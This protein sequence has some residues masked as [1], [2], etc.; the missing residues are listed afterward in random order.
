MH[1]ARQLDPIRIIDRDTGTVEVEVRIPERGM[2][3]ALRKLIRIAAQHDVAVPLAHRRGVRSLAGHGRASESGSG[4]V[5][6]QQI[7]QVLG[8][9]VQ[10]ALGLAGRDVATHDAARSRGRE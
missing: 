10:H 1:L 5:W 2:A 8:E 3:P 6:G 9:H 4:V 7:P